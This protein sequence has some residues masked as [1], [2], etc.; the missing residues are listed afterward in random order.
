[1]G[2]WVGGWVGDGKVE[3]NEAVGVRCVAGGWVGGEI[4]VG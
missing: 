4:G 2:G 1:M 3:E